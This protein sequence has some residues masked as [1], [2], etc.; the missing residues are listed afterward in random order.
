VRVTLRTAHDDAARL[1]ARR[2][3][4]PGGSTAIGSVAVSRSY[5]RFAALG[6][7]VTYGLGDARRGGCRGWTRILADALGQ[8]H[9]VSLCNTAVP[10]ATAADVRARQLD[11]ALAHRPDVASLVVGLNDTMRSSWDPE[12]L[13]EDLLHIAGRLTTQGALLLTVR[14]HDHTR[15]LGLPR[16]LARPMRAR[17]ATLNDIYDEIDALFG[18]LRVDLSDHPEIY[19][20]DFW[21]IDRLHPSELGHRALADR[22]AASLNDT[23]LAFARPSL[24]LDGDTP[25]RLHN[26]HWLVAKGAPW[27]ARRARDLAPTIARS[28]ITRRPTNIRTTCPSLPASLVTGSPSN[29]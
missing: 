22:F 25:T 9:D 13:R 17:I 3:P 28:Y 15:V 11:T 12:V 6:D 2:G 8:D 16:R 19:H 14:F 18:G 5:I 26:L 20:R 24:H 29:S 10:G 21:S 4:A 27:V 23:G 1:R 7:S